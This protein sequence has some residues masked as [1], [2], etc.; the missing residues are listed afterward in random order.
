MT[1]IIVKVTP[2]ASQNQI[3]GWEGETLK[4]RIRG[5]PEKGRVNEELVDF[6]SEE[7]GVPKSAIEIASGHTSRLKRLKIAGNPKF[8]EKK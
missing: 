3:V 4:V 5:V 1:Q 2:N 7:F 6:L 8:P